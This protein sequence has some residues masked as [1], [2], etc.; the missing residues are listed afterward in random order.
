MGKCLEK[1]CFKV[2]N[3]CKVLQMGGVSCILAIL[4]Y[5]IVNKYTPELFPS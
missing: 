1:L 4:I 2:P 5:Y 3:H